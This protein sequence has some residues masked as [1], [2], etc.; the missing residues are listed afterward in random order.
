MTELTRRILTVQPVADGGGSEHAL[1]RM[2]RQLSGAGWECHVVVPE[3]ARL[4]GEYTAAGAVLH[5]MPMDRLTTTGRHARWIRFFVLWPVVVVR[6]ALLARRLGADVVH[7]N[8]LHSWYGWAAARLTGRPHVWHAREIVFQSGAALRVERFL[9]ARFAARVIAVSGTVAAQL[10][11]GN[12]VVVT[13]EADPDRFDPSRAGRFRAGQGIRDEVPLAGSVGRLD[14]WKGFDVLL[15]AVP[16]IRGER[17]DFELVVV[18]GPVGGKEEYA[19]RLEQRARLLPGVHW[20]GAR[21]DV[22]DLMA[23][24]DVFVAVSTEP[25][26]FGLVVVEAL[27]SGVPVVAGAAGGPLEI[28]G[29]EAAERTA[30]AGRLVAPGDPH[31]L[32]AAV[33]ELLPPRS[34][35]GQRRARRPLRRPAGDC[36]ATVFDQVYRVPRSKPPG[37]VHR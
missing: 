35:S 37:R 20:L 8:S 15:D 32:A 19:R 3:P 26:P 14:T 18:G 1:I 25:E 34:D 36:F 12:V 30:P 23:D 31:A 11:P 2:I 28:L 6:L 7:S 10:D 24:L 4:A 33:L 27:A 9:A 16:L 22:G 13:D 17:P 5:V 21:S 29:R